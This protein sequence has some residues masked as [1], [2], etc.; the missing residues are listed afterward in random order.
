MG[1]YDNYRISN[2]TAIPQFVGSAGEDFIKVGQYKQGLYDQNVSISNTIGSQAD[3]INSTLPQDQAAVD[4]LRKD[5]QSKIQEIGKRGDW[6]NSGQEVQQ[7][8][9]HFANRSRE[10]M[11]PQQQ[12]ADYRKGLEEKELNLTPEQ[13][14]GLV[15]MSLQGYQGLKKNARGQYVGSFNGQAAAKN[16]D[17]NKKVDEWVKDAAIA[18]YGSEV[19]TMSSDDGGMWIMKNGEKLEKLLPDR[20]KEIVRNASSNDQEYQAYKN[21]EGRLAGYHASQF[22]SPNQLPDGPLKK[23]AIDTANKYG[24]PF[25]KAY[26]V[27]A[28]QAANGDV[29]NRAMGYAVQKYFRDNRETVHD[30]KDNPYMLK[31]YGTKEPPT[32]IP[33]FISQGPDSKLT[34]DERDLRKLTRTTED[35]KKSLSDTRGSIDKI[36]KDLSNSSLS[37]STRTQLEAEK[38]TLLKKQDNVQSQVN[39]S[40]E[41]MGYSKDRTAQDM[42][43]DDY[44]TFLKHNSGTL[45][46]SIN[47]IF[48]TGITTVGGKKLSVDDLTEAA[49][50]GRIRPD[51]KTYSGAGGSSAPNTIGATIVMKDGSKVYLDAKQKGA[52]LAN[53]VSAVTDN[54]ST[55]INKFNKKLSDTHEANVRDFSV[56]TSNISLSENDRKELAAHI[57]SNMDGVRFSK[58]GQVDAVKPPDDI[59]VYTIGTNGLGSDVKIRVEGA[60]KDG[61]GTGD[62]YDVTMGNSN[63]GDI[64]SSKL[65]ESNDPSSRM[66]A[67]MLQANSGARQLLNNIP[68]NKIHVGQ[69]QV[70]GSKSTDADGIDVSVK[71]T[72]S[73]DGSIS[74]NLIQ[75][76]NGKIL[77]TSGSAGV[78]GSW[79]DNLQSKSTYSNGQKQTDLNV[80]SR[81]SR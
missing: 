15:G 53:S 22:S 4:E 37:P 55:A 20:I 65:G 19:E 25:G 7:L 64:I 59:K 44:D 43:Y 3:E 57:K 14:Q 23:A 68:G 32:T 21:Q 74:Y 66:A 39:R 11:A 18:K 46:T 76:D 17:V 69:M 67:D 60:D 80:K 16:I 79:I 35:N 27:V 41:I 29:D 5:T 48:P 47:K 31:D 12:F 33:P 63:I 72:R 30:M 26:Q 6:E 73:R 56:Q 50:D 38:N 54:G 71:I 10:I 75:E 49:A 1:L 2:S 45:R 58:P 24:V 36:N 28:E 40:D 78:A 70:P 34:D 77:K 42:G 61:K 9:Q 81:R 8:G 51:V 52:A 62:Y 13:K